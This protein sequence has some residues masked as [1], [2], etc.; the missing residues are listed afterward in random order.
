M[1][2]TCLKEIEKFKKAHEKHQFFGILKDKLISNRSDG[3]TGSGQEYWDS[4]IEIIH[5]HYKSEGR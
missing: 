4:V 3:G 2:C 5:Q 1:K